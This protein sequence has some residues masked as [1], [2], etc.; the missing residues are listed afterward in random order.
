MNE[1]D[2]WIEEIEP[3]LNVRSLLLGISD[4]LVWRPKTQMV[5]PPLL[6]TAPP[7]E[8]GA[9]VQTQPPA[10]Q[11]QQGKKT[12]EEKKG[13]DLVIKNDDES[14]GGT[15]V[16]L[17]HNGI[18]LKAHPYTEGVLR[19]IAHIIE[20]QAV[21]KYLNK[22]SS[23][24]KH[25]MITFLE[26]NTKQ[27]TSAGV[28][29]L[30]DTNI[31]SLFETLLKCTILIKDRVNT[32]N[33][34]ALYERLWVRYLRSAEVTCTVSA[35]ATFSLKPLLAYNFEVVEGVVTLVGDGTKLGTI[36]RNAKAH[37][38]IVKEADLEAFS[39][40]F[41]QLKQYKSLMKGDNGKTRKLFINVKQG[42]VVDIA[43]IDSRSA[44]LWL[45]NRWNRVLTAIGADFKYSTTNKSL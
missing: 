37:H 39:I 44:S 12:P 4:I 9:Q 6:A 3:D 11:P 42:I 24:V 23:E 27:N 40:L 43:L 33:F 29:N 35:V 5:V 13:A 17:N 36:I 18:D 41:P 8:P 26:M 15:T 20:V 14:S 1:I 28:I 10:A 16:V 32:T 22:L 7:S 21:E 34:A 25:Q 45:S 38:Q 2:N 30:H 19:Q 31:I